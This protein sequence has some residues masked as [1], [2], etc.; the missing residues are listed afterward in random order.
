[1]VKATVGHALFKIE[2]TLPSMS[3]LSTTRLIFENRKSLRISFNVIVN[4]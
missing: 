1:M 4:I 3:I 2:I